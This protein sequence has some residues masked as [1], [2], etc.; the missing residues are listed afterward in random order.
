MEITFTIKNDDDWKKAFP[1]VGKDK[2]WRDGYSAKE[3]AKIVTDQYK[4][5]CPFEKTIKKQIPE[6]KDFHFVAHEAFPER[7]SRFD[8]LS[9]GRHHDLALLMENK[10]GERVALC[11]EAKVDEPFDDPLGKYISKASEGQ[12]KRANSLCKR[13][14]GSEYKEDFKDVF[15][16]LLSAT[17]GSV[18][19]AGEKNVS[20][21]YF[22]VFQILPESRPEVN[23]KA[24][25][26]ALNNFLKF[27]TVKGKISK[28]N[29]TVNLGNL[30]IERKDENENEMSA[31]VILAYMETTVP[32]PK[33]K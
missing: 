30:S 11:F 13:F 17:A 9:G 21:V 5:Y 8:S 1:P 3:F 22:V 15:Y 29:K 10:N 19:F 31:E 26:D 33:N 25:I 7:V 32:A 28:D 6:L 20:R 16:Q 18:A 2:Q 4:K 14:L 24:H 12:I 27:T 23:S